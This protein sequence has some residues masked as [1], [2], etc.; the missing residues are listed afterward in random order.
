VKLFLLG[1]GLLLGGAAHAQLGVQAGANLTALHELFSRNSFPNNS[2]ACVGYEV[3]VSYELPLGSRWAVV[4]Q[5]Q[6]S[7]ESQQ[8]RKEGFGFSTYPLPNGEYLIHDY[9]LS[10]SYLNLPVLLRRYIGPAYLE[11]GPQVSL[12]VGGRGSGETRSV[13]VRVTYQ[14]ISQAATAAYQRIETA[15]CLGAGVRLPAGWQAGVRAYWG[16]MRSRPE[17]PKDYQYSPEA[18]P[19]SGTQY[20]R[21]VQLLLTRQLWAKKV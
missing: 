2:L 9:Q 10:C 21:T 4:P 14:P 5:L 12:L 1:G 20:R 13:G 8:L 7:R 18:M 19:I 3:G 17:D 15:V 16:S 11:A 6:F